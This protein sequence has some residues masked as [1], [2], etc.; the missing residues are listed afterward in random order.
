MIG[1]WNYCASQDF[2]KTDEGVC[3][4]PRP[5]VVA[6]MFL[7]TCTAFACQSYTK[8]LE[9]SVQRADETAA[10]AALRTLSMAQQTY[11][12]SNNGGYGTFAQLTQSG[13]LDSRFAGDKPKFKGY[14]LTMEIKKGIDSEGGSYT[15]NADPEPP[16]QGRHFYIDSNS[17]LIHLNGGQPAGPSDPSLDQ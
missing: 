5:L 17:G 3:E 13:F 10:I 4:M 15:V 8:S 12:V 1:V 14:V 11:S 16:Q 7:L 2:R 6:L 9:Q